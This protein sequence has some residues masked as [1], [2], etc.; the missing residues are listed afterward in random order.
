MLNLSRLV[1]IFGLAS[2][3]GMP[4]ALAGETGAQ[5]KAKDAKAEAGKAVGEAKAKA[6]AGKAKDGKAEAGKAVGDA[7][8]K[9]DAGKAKDGKA[10]AG[11]AVG[12]AKA[13]A[14]AGKAKDGKA[15]AGKTVGDAT[16][17][18]AARKGEKQIKG[19]A[20]KQPKAN[21]S[22]VGAAGLTPERNCCS[23]EFFPERVLRGLL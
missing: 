15:E 7:K 13:K 21:E 5:G 22:P 6:D 11:K 18:A 10:E 9:A 14:D 3:M 1:A 16:A 19:A 12:D 8:A 20:A 23:F 2:C 4:P 17:K